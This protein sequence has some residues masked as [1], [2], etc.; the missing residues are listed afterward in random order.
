MKVLPFNS[1]RQTSSLPTQTCTCGGLEAVL[2]GID[3][4]PELPVYGNSGHFKS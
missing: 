4:E 1:M 3:N 2:P